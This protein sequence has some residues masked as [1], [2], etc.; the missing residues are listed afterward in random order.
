LAFKL[1][2]FILANYCCK[3]INGVIY[4]SKVVIKPEEIDDFSAPI[5]I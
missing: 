2:A 5:Q 1:R 4:L 3:A